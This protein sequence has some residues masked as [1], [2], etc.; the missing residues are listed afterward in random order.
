MHERDWG[1]VI[2]LQ[3]LRWVRV[4]V[5][6]GCFS[7]KLFNNWFKK[8]TE[9]DLFLRMCLSFKMGSK[10]WGNIPPCTMVCKQKKR[11]MLE[12]GVHQSNLY[13]YFSFQQNLSGH[14]S[15]WTRTWLFKSVL[16][17]ISPP[18]CEKLQSEYWMGASLEILSKK[19]KK[20]VA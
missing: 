11:C 16:S 18:S 7:T 20:C 1:S 19:K 8:K 14:C 6:A 5:G 17:L 10:S 12:L 4:F 2:E 9:S 13:E 3:W 15:L